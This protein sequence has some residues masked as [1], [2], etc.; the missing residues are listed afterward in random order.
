VAYITEFFQRDE[1]RMMAGFERDVLVVLMPGEEATKGVK[2]AIIRD[3]VVV[4][5][6]PQDV[7]AKASKMWREYEA[8]GK[9]VQ[10]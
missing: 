1:K 9:E 5:E 4:Q 10:V 7:L 8:R 3:G 2:K 6:F